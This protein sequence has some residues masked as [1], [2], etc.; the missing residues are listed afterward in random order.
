[1]V[2]VQ[3]QLPDTCRTATRHFAIPK[4]LRFTHSGGQIEFGKESEQETVTL[5]SFHANLHGEPRSTTDKI[6]LHILS[7]VLLG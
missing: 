3:F 1:M 2:G 7:I 4:M 5:V 6:C